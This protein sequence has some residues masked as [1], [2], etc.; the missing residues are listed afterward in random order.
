MKGLKYFEN[1]WMPSSESLPIFSYLPQ[2]VEPVQAY[3]DGL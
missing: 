2:G 3:G 1:L